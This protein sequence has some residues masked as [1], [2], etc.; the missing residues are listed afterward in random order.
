[1]VLNFGNVLTEGLPEAVMRHPAGV[2]AYLGK[3]F[4]HA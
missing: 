1:V 3:E 4:K 2:E